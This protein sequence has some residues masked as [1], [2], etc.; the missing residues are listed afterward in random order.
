[1][2]E[3]AREQF[4]VIIL[5][6]LLSRGVIWMRHGFVGQNQGSRLVL[7]NGFLG[8]RSRDRLTGDVRRN[9]PHTRFAVFLEIAFFRTLVSAAIAWPTS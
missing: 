4:K 3:I 9:D 6:T 2:K 5:L 1:V 8:G 7:R